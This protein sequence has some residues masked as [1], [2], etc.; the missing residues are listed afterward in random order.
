MEAQRTVISGRSR[1][2]RVGPIIPAGFVVADGAGTVTTGPEIA[3]ALL[4]DREECARLIGIAFRRFGIRRDEAEELLA[5]TLLEL[6]ASDAVI[7]SPKGFA[8][9]VFYTRCCR[10]LER[11]VH[12][13]EDSSG[14]DPGAGRL[15]GH[16]AVDVDSSLALK[17]AFGRLS[18]VCRRLL[19][20]YYVEGLSLKETA[21]TT[22]YSSKQVWKRLDGCLRR[23]KQC[24]EA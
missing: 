21:E 20:G 13:R 23:L 15:K 17:Q 16:S 22:G 3:E 14:L 24:L 2:A 10:W 9:H 1:S 12:R 7:R 6:S 11:E 8:F 4:L 19:V 18:A 5:E